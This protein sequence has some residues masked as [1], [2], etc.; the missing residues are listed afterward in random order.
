MKRTLSGTVLGPDGK[1][2]AGATVFWVATRIPPLAF[3]ALPKDRDSSPAG[4]TEIMPRSQ[5]GADGAFSLSAD[6]DPKRYERDITL[7]ARATG[8]GIL[9]QSIKPDDA[10]VTLRMPAEVVI[11]GR[12]LTPGGSPAQGVRV[13]LNGFYNDQQPGG[14]YV[15]LHPP[16]KEVPPYWPTPPATDADGKF[17]LEGVPEGYFATLT[18]W[19]PDYAVDDV[20]VNTT[21]TDALTPGL[22]A[23]EI[24][25][26]KPT[27]THTLEPARP[28]QG[29]VTDKQTGK[30]LAGLF[31]EMIPMRRHGGMPFTGRTDA[32]GR[33]RISGHGGARFFITTVFP[34]AD[35]GYLAARD[36]Q[37]EWPAGAKFLEKNFALEKGLMLH[38]QVIDAGT[39][40]PIPGA[41]VV[42]QPSRGNPNNRDYDLRNPVLT[43]SDGRFS[44]TAL[45]GEGFLA[46]ETPDENFVRVPTDDHGQSRTLYPQGLA[47]VDLAAGAEPKPVEIAVRKGITLEARAIGPDGKVVE[48]LIGCCEGIDAKL[49][50]VWNQGAL[51]QDGVFRLPGADPAHLSRLPVEPQAENWRGGRSQA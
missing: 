30:P 3:V 31:V 14:M 37:F 19:H 11:H 44:I 8:L 51:F 28:V 25:P 16:E 35:S 20:V 42:Y 18:F 29:R 10:T 47:Q 4:G 34:R 46:V 2:V 13:T 38:G 27:F 41:A 49:I 21:A 50:D 43:G 40:Q 7:V 22:K 17:T 36:T 6:F 24:T 23:G 33:Y 48:G 26:V 15:G 32:G 5:T 39:K 1:P 9:S 45:P 12:L